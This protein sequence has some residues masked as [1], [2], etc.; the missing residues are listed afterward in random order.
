V[1]VLK[2]AFDFDKLRS[3]VKRPGGFR[4]VFDAMNGVAGP[5]A[6]GTS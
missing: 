6:K 3:F 2:R 1:Q 5:Y 4:M